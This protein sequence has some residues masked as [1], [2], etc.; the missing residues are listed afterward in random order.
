MKHLSRLSAIA[1]ILALTL[2]TRAQIVVPTNNS[3]NFQA[4]LTTPS[5]KTLCVRF[6][7]AATSGKVK[8][9]QPPLTHGGLFTLRSLAAI[10]TMPVQTA[11][12]APVF[13]FAFEDEEPTALTQQAQAALQERDFPKALLLASRTIKLTPK[14]MT[15]WLIRA[16]VYDAQGDYA[17][18]IADYSQ[19][20]R[21]DPKSAAV[22]QARG[23]AHFKRG[24][25]A[26]SLVDFDTFL[27]LVPEQK[28]F[29]WQRGISL[30]YAGRFTEGKQQFELH[31]TVNSH[32]VENAVWHFLC[33]ARADGLES[34]KK[35]LISIEQDA[36][37]PMAQVHLLFAGKVLPQDVLAAAQAAPQNTRAGEPLFYAHLYLGLYFE[38]LGD[39]KRAREHI[40]KAATQ[41]KTNGYMGD[42][43]RVHA[44]MMN[45]RKSKRDTLPRGGR[46]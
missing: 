14:Q 4:C 10:A 23:G 32:D 42:V 26:E 25:I 20:L 17:K 43:A 38:A 30:Y 1:L 35:R 36:R 33:T 12:H 9:E 44:E 46:K 2:P 24:K 16:Q 34:A 19:V 37:V 27:R 6:H 40:F 45:R 3:I 28:P 5:G 7:D 8:Y 41:A 13:V 11:V 21:L 22:W 18:A 29:H 39:E 15:G 31:Q